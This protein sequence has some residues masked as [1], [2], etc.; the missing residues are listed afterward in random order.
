MQSRARKEH[1]IDQIN[2]NREEHE[3][4]LEYTKLRRNETLS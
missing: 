3:V 1:K 4:D 2:K